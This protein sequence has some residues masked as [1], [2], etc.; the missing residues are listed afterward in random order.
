MTAVSDDYYRTSFYIDVVEILAGTNQLVTN[1]KPNGLDTRFASPGAPPCPSQSPWNRDKKRPK[2][3]LADSR[4]H[5]LWATAGLVLLYLPF[6][7]A[8]RNQALSS[9]STRCPD[10][11]SDPQHN[12]AGGPLYLLICRRRPGWHRQRSLVG[13]GCGHRYR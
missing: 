13:N 3:R 7:M 6:G 2:R 11:N 5:P 10:H 9:E 12:P 1:I 4:K 8:G